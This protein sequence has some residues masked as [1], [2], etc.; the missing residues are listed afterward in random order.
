MT[1]VGQEGASGRARPSAGDRRALAQ[2]RIR[3]AR[4]RLSGTGADAIRPRRHGGEPPAS[5]SQERMWLLER[6]LDGYNSYEVV[7]LRGRL[8]VQALEEAF[9]CIV[10]RHEVLRTVFTER[11]GAPVPLVRPAGPAPVS[12]VDVDGAG[13]G[14]RL[15]RALARAEELVRQ[16]FDLAAESPL[17]V[18]VLRLTPADHLLV[19]V[20]H[21]IAVDGSS[22]PLLWSELSAAYAAL[23]EGRRPDL[24]EL[25]IQ[26]ADYAA[27]SR[28]RQHGE[29]MTRQ[30]AYWREHL[31]G[32]T[33]TELFTDRPRPPVRS[34][35]GAHVRFALPAELTRRLTELGGQHKATFFMVL[36]AA[37]DATLRKHTAADDILIGTPIAG[38]TRAETE[39]LIGYFV[40]TLLMRTDL[41]GDPT[42]TELLERVRTT[43]LDAY[44]NQE[45]PFDA[46]LQELR[47]ERDPSRNPL[48]QIMFTLGDEETTT[49]RLPGLEAEPVAMVAT[50]SRFDL[51]LSLTRRADTLEGVAIYA[52]DLFERASIERF[53]DR[54]QR[55]LHN[56]A[57]HPERRLSAID[58]LSPGEVE[59][60]E[61]FNRTGG[62]FPDGLLHELVDAQAVRS[63][64]AVAVVG[65]DGER[66]SYAEVVGR[67]NAL[68]HR[69]VGLGVGPDV[70]V[71][72]WMDRSVEML[73]S[74]LGV[75]K[76]GGA[77]VPLDPDVP[78]ARAVTVLTDGRIR[79]VC[80]DAGRAVHFV[81]CG[82]R[83]VVCD[84]L[85]ESM[86]EAPVVPLLPDHLV[87]VYFTSGSTGRPKGVAS[88][89]RGWVNRMWWMQECYGIGPGETVLHKTILSF[90]DSAVELFWPLITGATVVML[91]AGLHRDPRAILE[92]AVRH[93]VS[94]LQ[95]VPSML[96]LFLD[97]VAGAGA[98]VGA[99]GLGCLR[100]VVSSGEALQPYVVGRFFECLGGTPARLYN[101]WGATEVSID[102]TAHTCVVEDV[103]RGAVPL[104]VPIANNELL[105]LDDHLNPV[106][107]GVPGDLYLAGV[108]L[109]RGYWGDPR[110]TA[111]VFVPHPGRSGGRLYRTGDQGV[112]HGDG[113]ITFL[114]RSDH[115]IKVRGIRVEPGEIE[116]VL[117]SHPVVLEAIVTKWEPTPGDQRLAAYLVLGDGAPDFD[118]LV[119]DLEADLLGKLPPYLVPGSF[120]PIAAVPTNANGK[121]DTKRLPVPRVV[122]SARAHTAPVTDTEHLIADI[123][124]DVLQHPGPDVHTNFFSLGG[125]SLLAT[126]T[127]SRL[128]AALGLNVPLT[129][130]F[131]HPT[132]HTM[133]KAVDGLAPT[134]PVGPA[135]RTGT[136]EE[137]SPSQRRLWFLEE[138]NPGT[139]EYNVPSAIMFS[140][141]L[142]S[143]A[144]AAALRLVVDRHHVLRSR[145]V[146]G[147]DDVPR[148]RVEAVPDF[149]VV[150]DLRHL[151]ADEART[152]ADALAT[153]DACLPFDLAEGPWLRARIVELPEDHH[154]LVLVVHHIAVDGSSMTLLWSE[155]SA[156]YTA[157]LG[158]RR[159][160]L[161]ELPIQYADYAAWSRER[162]HSDELA[163]QLAH[164]RD[165]LQ[166]STG[167]ELHP[168]RPRPP[169]RDGN[170]AQVRLTLPTELAARLN[171]LAQHHNA[172]L[173]MVLLAAFDAT[174]RK[175]TAADDILIGTP[176]DGRT[177]AETEPLIGYFVNTLLM[178]TDLSGDPTFAQLLDRV[179]TTALDAYQNQE[180]PFDMLV[181]ALR[182]ERD[183]SRN[184]LFQI[185][186]TLV[187]AQSGALEVPGATARPVELPTGSVRFDLDVTLVTHPDRIEGV[188]T[189]ATAL[190]DR[191]TVERLVAHYRRL[192]EQVVADAHRPL[193]RIG[194][195]TPDEEHRLRTG[196][197]DTAAAYPAACLHD[198]VDAQAA[199]TPH[200]V[201]LGAPG[202]A[203][204]VYAELAERSGRLAARLAAAGAGPGT[205][206]VAVVLERSPEAVLAVL[207]VLKAG[208]AYLPV[209][210][211]YP[212]DRIDYMLADSGARIV[213]T[214]QGLA[215]RFEDRPGAAVIDVDRDT[216]GD[217]AGTAP[218]RTTHPDDLAYV[219]YTS[220]STGRPKPV[221]VPHRGLAN[222][223]ADMARRLR[224][225]EEDTVL[226]VTTVSFDIAV[227]ELL[228]PLTRGARTVVA[229]RATA[230]DGAR[231]A[232]ALDA[233]SATL[234]QATP[235]TWHL[236]L[237][238]GWQ[239]GTL[240]AVCGGEAMSRQLAADLA[241]RVD[242]LWNAY[243][244]TETTVWSTAH[245]VE[246]SQAPGPV[247][248]GT[249]LSNTRAYVLDDAMG[250]API[251]TIG[252]L[253]LAGDGVV[254][255]YGGRPAATA[256]RF[257]PDPFGAGGRM[258]RTGDLARWRADGTLEFAGRADAQVKIRG[259]RIEPGE[260]ESVLQR[261][262]AVARC[263]VTVA[264]TGMD[265][266]L[267]GHVVWRE[268]EET[269]S[270]RAFARDRLPSHMVPSAFVSLE[271]LPLTPNGKVDVR[272][273]PE[274]GTGTGGAAMA[275]RD[276]LELRMT[277]L[278]QRILQRAPIGVR[279][280][281]FELGGHSLRAFE[282]MEAVRREFGVDVPLNALFRA[283]TVEGLC[284]ALPGASGAVAHL[285]VPM[286]E[287]PAPEAGRAPAPPLFLVH[288]HGGDVCCYV[289]LA[290]RLGG[291][292]PVYGL[293][294]V[295]YNTDSTPLERIEEIA[296]RYLDEIRTVAPEGPYRLAGWSFGGNVAFEMA[297]Q[298]E[299]AGDEVDFLGVIDAEALGTGPGP[300]EQDVLVRFGA[301]AGL[302]EEQ[303]RRLDDDHIIAALVRRSHER[304]TLPERT[305]SAAVRRMLAVARA[306]QKAAAGY[307]PGT[308]VTADVHLFTVSQQH[309]TLQAP[310][311]D[312]HA[313]RARTRGRVHEIELPGNHH[314]V[315]YPPHSAAVAERIE[316]A[317]Q[318]LNPKTDTAEEA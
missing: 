32:A 175:H 59:S 114:G 113:E 316:T 7:R 58:V 201:A 161:P 57:A 24:P 227:L 21:H 276:V 38:R 8:D 89:H 108:G 119:K 189:Y 254:R 179:R 229:D 270:L 79:F 186:F 2:E 35:E 311:V 282:L 72:L 150:T 221:Q 169:V 3:A 197:N 20:V 213:L 274:P 109:A 302:S 53:V 214:G 61:A 125:H 207:A 193:S 225:D 181:E 5:F 127:I 46:L 210:P 258:Y 84:V 18:T 123:W 64:D 74:L 263:A 26:Y 199:R 140:G 105:V 239:G 198:L 16:P 247:P 202:R 245:R 219:I 251:G 23:V 243:G 237:M 226:A 81:G 152:R 157:L 242:E 52:T 306:H 299:R 22:M 120:T 60:F 273:L 172:T 292:R 51:N 296:A 266:R 82:V 135:A 166:G 305:Q 78:P 205:P 155:L 206:P 250:L 241:D 14:E 168:D 39:P 1:A 309:P 194:V 234:V 291:T 41:S 101:Q 31:Q 183:L 249:P 317:L 284:A 271:A 277:G 63:P 190:L 95:F 268:G 171:A 192:L 287:G 121:L 77:Y 143:G 130:L 11:D 187:G 318:T 132:I 133:A 65:A 160:D 69:L 232:E 62:V 34:G 300:S 144:L 167:T 37:F 294:A 50:K 92:S 96:N 27:W 102:S 233:V 146:I 218:A 104:G 42:F 272:R 220:G 216:G 259:H 304:E 6:M 315:V 137:L 164:W 215:A 209:D 285:L 90:D 30:L 184:P 100:H 117:R 139:A 147:D 44:H 98:G 262:P 180:L 264:G 244:P 107:V 97:E 25:P 154:L 257:L 313:W 151:P 19:V 286:A 211:A 235:A 253:Y 145:I 256:E 188:F 265:R 283:P 87:S 159:P 238:S 29:E 298:L 48:F 55:F 223:A 163:E 289:D 314:D 269:A 49:L 290:R 131:D 248:I 182:P 47:P 83:A 70:P 278:W 54:F 124:A 162:Q 158:G 191:E 228:V 149:L 138:L 33:G 208:A 231:L 281:F 307:R 75:L 86:P 111:D 170:G 68:A 28:E 230:S 56:A 110:K 178:R 203:D 88:T 174:L 116:H 103:E 240:R 195:L 93:R 128:R 142:D 204:M 165:R 15:S 196:W 66:V 312:P 222:F 94:V 106:P 255:G 99:G 176:I 85:T 173:Y 73:V 295:G 156:A 217:P 224:L 177:R 301:E 10:E 126:R 112:R 71:G 308:R 153:D 40:N 136:D 252:E 279:D 118:A 288:P 129:L 260:T 275:P 310:P 293:E 141:T 36:L 45:L 67:A 212:Q 261:H 303:V 9:S 17:R 148:Q 91:G 267:V 280:D 4:A 185:M 236:L 80:T 134:A 297:A 12:L 122:R 76:A 43:A 115:Q 246:P 200:A 13:G